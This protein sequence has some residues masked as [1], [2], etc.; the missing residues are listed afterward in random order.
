MT[1]DSSGEPEVTDLPSE[2]RFVLRQDGATAELIYQ[3]EGGRLIILHTGV[4]DEMGGQGIGGR[5]VRAAVERAGRDHLTIVPVCPFT[6]KWLHEHPDVAAT[7]EV[8]FR[9]GLSGSR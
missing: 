3:V 8:D 1:T 7:S 4:P 5:L 9:S 6:R 2:S